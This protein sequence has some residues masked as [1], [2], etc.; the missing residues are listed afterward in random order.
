MNFHKDKQIIVAYP[1][2]KNLLLSKKKEILCKMSNLYKFP[3]SIL[4]CYCE[5]VQYE[6]LNKHLI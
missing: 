5:V 6:C 2:S 3:P 1:N 4:N